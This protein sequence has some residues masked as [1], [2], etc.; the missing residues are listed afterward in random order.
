MG[1][2]TEDCDTGVRKL[3]RYAPGCFRPED[4]RVATCQ[5]KN[6]HTNPLEFVEHHPRRS[7]HIRSPVVLVALRIGQQPEVP[8]LQ[9]VR[10]H[11]FAAHPRTP[12]GA[13]ESTHL[14]RR[15]VVRLSARRSQQ[16]PSNRD[17]ARRVDKYERSELRRVEGRKPKDFRSAKRPRRK[18]CTI[19]TELTNQRTSATAT[20]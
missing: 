6:R 16:T 18:G 17:Q 19:E 13:H 12:H 20:M 11:D 9:L 14:L 7:G 1:T 4:T 2:V 3:P 10:I 5:E 15:W 8:L